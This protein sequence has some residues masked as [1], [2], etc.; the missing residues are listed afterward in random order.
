MPFSPDLIIPKRPSVL[1]PEVEG[2]IEDIQL[3]VETIADFLTGAE[4][5]EKV[6]RKS[7][8]DKTKKELDFFDKIK[9]FIKS[10]FS[11]RPTVRLKDKLHKVY[12]K[13]IASG[14]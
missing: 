12:D 13:Y 5:K 14:I 8:T 3:D 4:K 11:S 1:G 7:D 10:Q 6:K 9:F 2:T